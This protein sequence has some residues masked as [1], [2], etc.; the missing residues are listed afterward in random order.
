MNSPNITRP[1]RLVP[2]GGFLGS[3]KTT[4]LRRPAEEFETEG[5]RVALIANDQASNLVDTELLRRQGL[6]VGEVSG[7]CFCCRFDQLVASIHNLAER[8][9]PEIILAEPV[10]SC[11]DLAATV[12]RP[13]RRLYPN[14]V[15]VAPF[16]VLVDPGRLAEAFN[17]RNSA[18][19]TESVYYILRKQLEEAD[20]IVINKADLLSGNELGRIE[21]LVKQQFPGTPVISISARTGQGF[22]S[23]LALVG[24]SRPAGDRSI[25]VDYDLYAEG[26]AVLGWLNARAELASANGSDW[27]VMGAHL[28][29]NMRDALMTCG[30][31]VAHIK[32]FLETSGGCIS[33]NLTGIAD[34][35]WLSGEV[36][37]QSAEAS[38]LVNARAQIA[39]EALR[40]TFEASLRACTG[41]AYFSRI[42]SLDCFKPARPVPTHRDVGVL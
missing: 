10:G 1:I 5:R 11:T 19:F 9:Q 26:E 2:V 28:L 24:E 21:G 41:T 34:G 22:D 35:P 3:G 16:T 39:P 17:E 8:S 29:Q 13:L 6:A 15:Q 12:V 40:T 27:K 36:A 14:E 4:L 23:W 7:G 42:V 37:G 31:E 32:V 18:R 30:C 33:G 38:L 20:A 25:D